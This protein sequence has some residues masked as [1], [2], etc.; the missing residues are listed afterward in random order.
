MARIRT[1][2]PEFWTDEKVVE[3]SIEARLLFIGMFNFSDDN[4]NLVNS[5]KR[6]KMQ[7]FPA[8]MIECD[9]LLKELITHGLLTEYSVNGVSY[10]NIKGFNKHQKINRPSKTDI[11]K[12]NFSEDSV[13][14]HGALTDG[15]DLEGKG[16][17]GKGEEL[18]PNTQAAD[19]PCDDGVVC[20]EDSSPEEVSD[21]QDSKEATVHEISGRYAFEG[22]V[23]R[24][25][26]KDYEA[27]KLLYPLIDLN[28]ELH[29]LDIEF[30]N[31]KPKNWFITASQKLS[32]QN[33][34]AGTRPARKVANGLQSENFATK[35]YG[36]TEIP[37]W[38][39]E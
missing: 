31:E 7:V 22:E 14:T 21:T 36:T 25:N 27:W 37:S 29:K 20:Q 33:K 13:N 18:E 9:S 6:I 32:Y 3:C 4:G 17:E 8:D 1:V 5:P 26:H 28:Y 12:Q 10:L 15:K 16:R 24:L 11:P 38:A 23:V 2:K 35:D 30:A 34:Q 19:A 39:R